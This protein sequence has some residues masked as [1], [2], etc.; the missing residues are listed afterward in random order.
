M[1]TSLA[2]MCPASAVSP[3]THTDAAPC[4]PPHPAVH[5]PEVRPSSCAA[6][7]TPLASLSRTGD[8]DGDDTAEGMGTSVKKQAVLNSPFP[9]AAAESLPDLAAT[10]PSK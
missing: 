2:R 6:P 5:L 9:P 10:S 7:A 4:P 3:S 1:S 8:C